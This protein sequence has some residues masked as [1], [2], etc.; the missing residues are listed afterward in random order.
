MW[1]TRSHRKV[2]AGTLT[3]RQAQD[4]IVTDWFK[5]YREQILK[6]RGGRLSLSPRETANRSAPSTGHVSNAF[7]SSGDG[8]RRV[9]FV[10]FGRSPTLA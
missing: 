5:Y 3:L 10:T 7:P 4:I 9:T 8:L 1:K 2:C 6:K